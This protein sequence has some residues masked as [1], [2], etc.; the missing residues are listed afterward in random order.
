MADI[1][2]SISFH[3]ELLDQI[4]Q[5]AKDE[6]RTQSELIHEAVRMYIERKKERQT[7]FA[8]GKKIG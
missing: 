5:I 8:I 1:T 2:V 4:N 6:A 7:I 3:E